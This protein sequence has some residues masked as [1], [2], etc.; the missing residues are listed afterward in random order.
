M[1][2]FTENPPRIS[3][4]AIHVIKVHSNGTL[5]AAARHAAAIQKPQRKTILDTQHADPASSRR[6]QD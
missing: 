3:C 5:H 2:S 6:V 1:F 4:S